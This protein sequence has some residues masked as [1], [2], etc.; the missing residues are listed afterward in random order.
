MGPSVRM[1]YHLQLNHMKWSLWLRLHLC[2]EPK[3]PNQEGQNETIAAIDRE[4]LDLLNWNPIAKPEKTITLVVTE[5]D[6]RTITNPPNTRINQAWRRDRPGL[7]DDS[8]GTDENPLRYVR[9]SLRYVIH[10]QRRI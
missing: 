9:L 7:W 5:H 10:L 3:E 6:V 4:M 2:H 1:T 8:S